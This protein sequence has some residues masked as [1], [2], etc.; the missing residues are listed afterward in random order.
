VGSLDSSR[1]PISLEDSSQTSTLSSSFF[2][3]S[4]SS[5]Q[6]VTSR[7]SATTSDSSWTANYFRRLIP[8]ETP[9]QE[10]ERKLLTDMNNLSNR[11]DMTD[12]VIESARATS[13][14]LE[15]IR[16]GHTKSQYDDDSH[17]PRNSCHRNIDMKAMSC[18][19]HGNSFRLVLDRN[20]GCENNINERTLTCNCHGRLFR[21]VSTT[22]PTN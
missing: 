5:E 16:L 15:W 7:E 3:S 13:L 17:R 19:C 11:S 20:L 10:W 22:K 14:K 18:R 8:T 9:T 6:S 21:F 12:A 2:L 4:S 1:S